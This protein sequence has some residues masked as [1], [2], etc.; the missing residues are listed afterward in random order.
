MG[1]LT[2]I[3][4]PP[5]SRIIASCD[6]G[7]RH[8]RSLWASSARRAKAQMRATASKASTACARL[9]A[10]P[11]KRSGPCARQRASKTSAPA[12]KWPVH[13]NKRAACLG[14]LLPRACARV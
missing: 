10:M 3:P 2:R 9:Q 8:E 13:K 4:V 14:K 1:S 7:L 12:N 11:P 5:A 6:P